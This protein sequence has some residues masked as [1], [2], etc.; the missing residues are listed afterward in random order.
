[1]TCDCCV[2]GV[3]Y[4]KTDFRQ[5]ADLPADPMTVLDRIIELHPEI[6][7]PAARTLLLTVLRWILRGDWINEDCA[8]HHRV[9]EVTQ[10]VDGLIPNMS[11]DNATQTRMF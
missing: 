2:L 4:G 11:V 9:K 10:I 1:M 3:D 6:E 5:Y 8:I 7:P